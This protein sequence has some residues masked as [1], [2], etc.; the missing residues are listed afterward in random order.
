MRFS[1]IPQFTKSA[2]YTVNIRFSQ[3][4]RHV[5]SMIEDDCLEL[6][7]D[8]QRGH[9]WSEEQ[10]SEFVWYFLRGGI[11]G[12][13]IY[14]NCPN[15]GNGQPTGEY[16]DFVCVDGLQRLT[17]LTKFLNGEI[18]A[19][20]LFLKDFEGP[21]SLFNNTLKFHINDLET[22]EEVITW[23]LEMN[24]GGKPHSLEELER[25]RNLIKK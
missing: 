7:P 19:N 20:G 10:Q 9:I 17:A 8:F 2:E 6:N 4:L 15:W 22:R 5:E 11:S 14:F 18:A 23:Y 24:T 3:L 13:D 21:L 16:K 25:V 12:R 1:N